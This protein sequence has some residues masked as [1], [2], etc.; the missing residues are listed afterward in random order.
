[1]AGVPLAGWLSEASGT[2]KMFE[3]GMAAFLISY[4]VVVFALAASPSVRRAGMGVVLANLLYTVAAVILVLADVFPLTTTGLVVTLG[5][6][7]YTLFF[8]E[9]QY[10]GWRRARA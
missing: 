1:V 3:Y 7:I 8:A 9:L 10:Q 5:S 6:G 4:G 2:T